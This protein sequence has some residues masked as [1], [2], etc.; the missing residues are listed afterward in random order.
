MTKKFT[1][2]SKDPQVINIMS[3]SMALRFT[4][5]E[6][7]SK[8]TKEGYKFSGQTFYNIKKKLKN[9]LVARVND[10]EHF[11]AITAIKKG[12]RRLWELS[13]T[14]T[15]PYRQGELITQALNTYPFLTTYYLNIKK[16]MSQ[17]KNIQIKKDAIHL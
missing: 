17:H 10:E 16:V 12:Q 1:H 8:L 4:E 2:Y 11:L 9:N 15:D 5:K 14:E 7:I 13:E 6:T 3:L